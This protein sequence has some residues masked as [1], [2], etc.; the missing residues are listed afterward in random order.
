MSVKDK[1][2]DFITKISKKRKWSFGDTNPYFDEVYTH[3]PKIEA[4]DL[5]EYNCKLKERKKNEKDRLLNI[6]FIPD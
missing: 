1:R 6:S 5:N 3:M 4:I 2:L